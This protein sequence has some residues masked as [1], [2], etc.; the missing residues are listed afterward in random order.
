MA[1]QIHNLGLT[2]DFIHWREW[3]KYKYHISIDGNSSPWSNLFQQLLKGSP[4]LKVESSRGLVQ[5]Y[6]D[7]LHPWHNY[8]PVA[9][10]MS[11]LV[12]KVKWLRRNDETAKA[13]GRRGQQLVEQLSYDRE[14]DR[15]APVISSAIRYFAGRT[16]AAGPY[17]RVVD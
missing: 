5:W 12:D 14:L 15:S 11:D 1:G 2:A 17:G 7:Q 13:I 6:Y 8:V 16:D 9:P 4:V 10:D 3:N